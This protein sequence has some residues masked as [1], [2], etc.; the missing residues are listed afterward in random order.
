MTL[1]YRDTTFC[2]NEQCTKHCNRFLTPQ[3]EQAAKTYGLPLAVASF[4]CLDKGEDGVYK[5][6]DIENNEKVS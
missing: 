1:V 6:E 5:C 4:I 3:I 2:V